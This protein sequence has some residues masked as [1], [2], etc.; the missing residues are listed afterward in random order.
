MRHRRE[1]REV[2]EWEE[3][4]V[5]EWEEVYAQRQFCL[6]GWSNMWGWK[7]GSLNKETP[8]GCG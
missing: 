6:R 1:E 8:L 4:E 2:P 3:R 5:P 7:F